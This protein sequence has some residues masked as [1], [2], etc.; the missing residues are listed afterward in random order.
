MQR[1][2][3]ISEASH[4]D[5]TSHSKLWWTGTVKLGNGQPTEEVSAAP[6]MPDETATGENGQPEEED[7]AEI[8]QRRHP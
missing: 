1:L 6:P 7:R 8:S 4:M 3:G 2:K 5:S